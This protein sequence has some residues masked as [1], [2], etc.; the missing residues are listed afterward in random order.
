MLAHGFPGH[1][2]TLFGRNHRSEC[3]LDR[4]GDRE[5]LFDERVQGRGIAGKGEGFLGVG[6]EYEVTGA[7]CCREAASRLNEGRF[8]LVLLGSMGE[9]VD[10]QALLT[11]ICSAVP[12]PK[13]ILLAPDFTD[14]ILTRAT[15]LQADGVLKSFDETEVAASVAA[16]L[17][18]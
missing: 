11:G 10:T 7:T 18:V 4:G 1:L 16:H 5:R 6:R 15:L 13:V 2:G 12:R 14:E 3:F 17:G 8:D 9:G